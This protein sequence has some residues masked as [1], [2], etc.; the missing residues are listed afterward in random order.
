MIII[1]Y[2]PIDQ[3]IIQSVLNVKKWNIYLS[4]L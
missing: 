1:L 3:E 4:F 2:Y